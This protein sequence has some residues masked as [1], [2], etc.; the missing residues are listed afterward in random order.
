[1]KLLRNR[2]FKYVLIMIMVA[3]LFI[4]KLYLENMVT[5]VD[6]TKKIY[7]V[8]K[9]LEEKHKIEDSDIRAINVSQLS[10]PSNHVSAPEE[11]VGKYVIAPIE[12]GSYILTSNVADEKYFE[13]DA[14]PEGYKMIS[15]ALTVDQAAGWK[16]NQ[17]Q[18]VD[19]VF[20][21]FQ[22]SGEVTTGLTLKPELYN[23]ITIE[24]VTIVDVINEALVSTKDKD[25]VGVPKFVVVL[26][27]EN[28]AEF[29]ALAKD[30]GRFDLLVKSN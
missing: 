30:K 16:I 29:L 13:K 10:L 7:I 1:M 26:V 5:N 14:I 11:V 6:T 27:K 25:F 22:Y 23:N 24:D 12:N 21:P 2:L 9:E 4:S 17:G 19:M 15:I 18:I 28:E 3:V 8:T 20:S